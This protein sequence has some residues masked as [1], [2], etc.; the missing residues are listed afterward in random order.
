MIGNRILPSAPRA[1]AELISAYAKSSTAIISDNLARLPG[2]IGVRPFHKV[3]GTMAGTALTVRVAAG[4]NLLIHKALDLVRPGD[5]VVVDGDGETNRA[6]IG[7][8]MAT[9]AQTRGAAGMVID[10]AI[11]DA[12]ALAKSEF[13]VFA[14][15]AIHRGPYKNGPGEINV[16]VAI[17]GFVIEP[18]DIVVG[19]EDGIVA[20]PQAVAVELLK[21]VHAQEQKEE[22]I[23]R[24]IRQGTYTGA[25]GTPA[26][27]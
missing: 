22:D 14:R 27:P 23:L 8:I 4:D 5:V 19:D 11:R 16:P 6:L 25:Y 21:A 9:I 18:G 26:S 3:N 15:A 7:E 20:F 17:G 1:D 2:V 12:G 10:G 24:S 13:P